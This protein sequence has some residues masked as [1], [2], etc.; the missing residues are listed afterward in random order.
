VYH[1]TENG[2]GTWRDTLVGG[3]IRFSGDIK[4]LKGRP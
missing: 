4:P 1:A 2:K 3:K